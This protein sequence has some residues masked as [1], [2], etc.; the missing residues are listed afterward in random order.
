MLAKSPIID[1]SFTWSPSDIVVFISAGNPFIVPGLA[2]Q[3]S[4]GYCL[5]P[6][7]F[8]FASS[9]EKTGDIAIPETSPFTP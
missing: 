5:T 2:P 9:C 1:L 6:L 7:T 8:N 4:S 3:A